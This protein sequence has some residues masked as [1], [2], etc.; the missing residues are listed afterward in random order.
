MLEHPAVVAW[1]ELQPKRIE[2]DQIELLKREKKSYVCRLAGVGQGNSAV[3]AK[4]CRKAKSTVERTVYAEVLPHL[5]V[6]ALHYYGAVEADNQYCWLFLEDAGGEKFSRYAPQHRVLAAQW[7]GTVHTSAP[8]VAASTT[9]P[10]RGPTHY[11]N[12]LSLARHNILNNL[13]NPALGANH[14][15]LL[16]NML[17]RLD[18]VESNWSELDALCEAVPRTLVHGDIAGRNIR[19]RQTSRE[20]TLVAFDWETAGWG[21]PAAD[22]LCVDLK[23]YWSVVHHYWPG[24]DFQVLQQL[25]NIGRLLRG[26][27]APISWLSHSLAYE[28]ADKQMG[29][30]E[31][32]L[33]TL[34]EAIR[35]VGWE[36]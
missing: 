16:D 4:R 6:A 24:M 9:L 14:R 33:I 8:V 21:V 31:A 34:L 2:P 35:A 3:I 29:T 23:A 25:T 11:L 30:M 7:L 19:V 12:H 36:N 26:A 5:P 27:I 15:K 18:F 20:L 22:L 17:T 10:D 32:Y 1:R 13:D 28:W